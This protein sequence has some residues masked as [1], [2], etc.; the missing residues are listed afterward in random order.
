MPSVEKVTRTDSGLASALRISVARLQRRL[1]S[2]RDPLGRQVAFLDSLVSWAAIGLLLVFSVI[3]MVPTAAAVVG[4]FL[5]GVVEAVEARHYPASP[6]RAR[7]PHP[8][9]LP[10]RSASSA[11][12]SSRTSSPRRLLR[13][14]AARPL[15]L[16]A[17]QRLPA[18][19]RVLRPRR[20]P[21]PA[22]RGRRRPRPPR[23]FWR[24]WLAGTAMVVPMSVPLLDLV[25]PVIGVA[26]FTHQFHRVAKDAPFS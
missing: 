1:R 19:P 7:R 23:Q 5:D 10:T 14:P 11:S 26:V 9:G 2:E 8:P 12:S 3:L 22:P 15:R 13:R 24:L 16:L 25:V 21:P 18:R 4:F 6:R 17:R 20:H